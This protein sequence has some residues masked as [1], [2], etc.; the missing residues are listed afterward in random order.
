MKR[1]PAGNEIYVY[2]AVRRACVVMFVSMSRWQGCSFIGVKG[3]STTSKTRNRRKSLPE[4]LRERHTHTY[5]HMCTK[6][7]KRKTLEFVYVL[8][9]RVC[10][11]G[12]APQMGEV[13]VG[14]SGNRIT[15]AHN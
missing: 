2:K 10:A 11:P 1:S 14:F 15:W 9:M 8:I 13:C 4:A 5:T 7:K 12:E 3:I 6:R